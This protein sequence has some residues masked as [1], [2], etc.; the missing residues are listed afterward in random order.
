MIEP[1]IIEI[2]NDRAI[3]IK[4]HHKVSRLSVY[5]GSFYD[6]LGKKFNK[7]TYITSYDSYEELE[8]DLGG[9][10]QFIEYSESEEQYDK[11]VS[12]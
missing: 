7:L 8:A 3:L 6:G 9:L 11:N 4:K 12:R 2:N 5:Y 1:I 10:L